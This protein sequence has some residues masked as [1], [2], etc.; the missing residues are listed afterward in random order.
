MAC[1]WF[2]AAVAF[3][4]I[5]PVRRQYASKVENPETGPLAGLIEPQRNR[6]KHEHEQPTHLMLSPPNGYRW[7]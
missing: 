4:L 5:R 2:S 6:R 3:S 7:W 1:S